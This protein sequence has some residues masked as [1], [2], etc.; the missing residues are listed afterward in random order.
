MGP[1]SCP[2]TMQQFAQQFLHECGVPYLVSAARESGHQRIQHACTWRYDDDQR[3]K[4]KSDT[5][6]DAPH[7]QSFRPAPCLA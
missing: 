4:Q 7:G 1:R 5:R 3:G 6:Q 2:I